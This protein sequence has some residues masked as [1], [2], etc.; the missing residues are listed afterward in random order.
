MI[1]VSDA[2]PLCYL[3]MIG[4]LH[5]LPALF[6]ELL[7]PVAVEKE[8]TAFGAPQVVREM[9]RQR[10]DWLKV[11]P[12]LAQPNDVLM[13]LHPGEREAI[14]LAEKVAADIILL[15]EKRA[16]TIALAQGIH[17]TGLLGILDKA[18]T[19]KLV[20]LSRAIERLSK[21]NFRVAPLLLK[22]LLE[23]HTTGG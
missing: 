12:V 14:L 16:R 17:V 20:A 23:R 6:R 11:H 18:A 2:S 3:T 5:L 13:Q 4:E 8:L 7:I 15:D 19:L 22:R 1:V 10:P 21:T 9:L